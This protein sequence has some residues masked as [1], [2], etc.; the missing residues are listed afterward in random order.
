[1]L[2]DEEAKH[3]QSEKSACKAWHSRP[4]DF[5]ISQLLIVAV[6]CQHVCISSFS[7]SLRRKFYDA[8]R[9]ASPPFSPVIRLR[10]ERPK[11]KVQQT[12][13]FSMFVC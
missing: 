5:L 3:V 2:G 8:G 7:R 11:P 10:H 9:L 6:V 4:V 12:K 1:M 13:L